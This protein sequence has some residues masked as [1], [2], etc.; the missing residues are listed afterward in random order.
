MLKFTP[1]TSPKK[2]GWL[3]WFEDPETGEAVGYLTLDLRYV[4]QPST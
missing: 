1:Y 2:T 3:G 4:P